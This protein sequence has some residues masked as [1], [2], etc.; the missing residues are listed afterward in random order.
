MF[1][2]DLLTIFLNSK[3]LAKLHGILSLP[4]MGSNEIVLI[5]MVIASSELEFLA[6]SLP[7]F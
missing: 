1:K 5:L 3:V 6:N 2:Q 7:R 4:S